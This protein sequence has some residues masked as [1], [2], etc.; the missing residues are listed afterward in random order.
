MFVTGMEVAKID[1]SPKMVNSNS[2]VFILLVLV[3]INSNQN[4]YVYDG[5]K[6]VDLG[7]I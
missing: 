5:S 7:L 2:L 1:G 4:K 3:E 6:Q